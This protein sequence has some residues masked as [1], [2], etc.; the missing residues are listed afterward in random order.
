MKRTKYEPMNILI[1]EQILG[2]KGKGNESLKYTDI[3]EMLM[4]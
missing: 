4:K 1:L 3:D 2:G